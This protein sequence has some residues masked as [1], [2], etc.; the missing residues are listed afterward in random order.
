MVLL[1][2]QQ[3]VKEIGMRKVLGAS[4]QSISLLISK[5]FIVLVLIAVVI[6]TP[7]SWLIMN[8]WLQDFPYRISLHLWMFGLVALAALVIAVLTIGAN[9]IK[10]ARQNPIKS[11]RTE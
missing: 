7:I 6:A 5:D 4:V 9:T 2:I 3:R 11:L 1:I 10:A 8:G